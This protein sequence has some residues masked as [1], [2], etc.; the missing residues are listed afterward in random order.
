MNAYRIAAI[1]LAVLLLAYPLSTGP[2]T[3]YYMGSSGSDYRQPP[4]AL[5]SFYKPL[6]WCCKLSPVRDILQRYEELWYPKW[7]VDES[8]L[9]V[10]PQEGPSEQ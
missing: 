10:T 1:V 8:A 9:V 7:F 5:D 3:R 4:K 2:V 6:R